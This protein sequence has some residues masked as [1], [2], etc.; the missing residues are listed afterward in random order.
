V[1]EKRDEA[2][3]ELEKNL[4]GKREILNCREIR[5]LP[6]GNRKSTEDNKGTFLSGKRR[7]EGGGSRRWANDSGRGKIRDST[8]CERGLNNAIVEKGK[9]QKGGPS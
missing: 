2:G 8:P 9:G 7:G 4:K 5:N 3:G 6:K 1:L